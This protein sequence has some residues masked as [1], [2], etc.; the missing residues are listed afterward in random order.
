MYGAGG[1]GGLFGFFGRMER[2]RK[3]KGS[4]ISLCFSLSVDLPPL[5]WDS[6]GACGRK[7]Q[8]Q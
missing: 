6:M 7:K 1:L 3:G 4:K 8:E 5:S 2:L